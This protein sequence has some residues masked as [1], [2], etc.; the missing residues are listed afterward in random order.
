[1]IQNYNKNGVTEN[2]P[3]YG[4]NFWG[5]SPDNNY[6]FGSTNIEK[7]VE[8]LCREPRYWTT[9]AE[10]KEVYDYVVQQEGKPSLEFQWPV[11]YIE[12][13]GSAALHLKDDYNRLKDQNVTDKYKHALMNC[14]AAQYGPGGSHA[15][16]LASG[17]KEMYD[18]W[19]GNNT[20]DAS[21]ADNYAN[22]IGRLLGRKYPNANCDELLPP[23]IKKT[24]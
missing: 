6:G 16:W 1:M 2:Y 23:Y 7:N 14:H 18:K 5:G 17:A 20:S 10:G 19:S 12:S 4:T 24:Y 13:A 3:Q 8:Q 9:A 22:E 15:A 21:D 11:G